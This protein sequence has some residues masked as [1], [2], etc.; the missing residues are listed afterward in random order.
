MKELETEAPLK[1]D[2][3]TRKTAGR[4]A[5]IE[6][7][8][9]RPVTDVEPAN[10]RRVAAE[11]EGREVTDVEDVEE[12]GADLEVRSFSKETRQA[13]LL[14]QAHINIEV[15]RTSERITSDTRRRHCAVGLSKDGE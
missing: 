6:V 5:E 14:D 2:D 8:S 9:E 12:I 13:G 10:P 11:A 7:G 1:F 4:S 3:A 15:A